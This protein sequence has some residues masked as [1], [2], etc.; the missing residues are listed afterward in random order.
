[1]CRDNVTGLVWEVKTSIPG[2]HHQNITYQ[3]GGLTAIGRKHPNRIGTYY[4]PSWNE[5]V[6][7]SN[8]ENLCGFNDWRLPTVSEL[9]SIVNKGSSNITIDA[10]Y[11][12][13][14]NSNWYWSSS[15]YANS[16]NSA[17]IVKL[18]GGYVNGNLR[19]GVHHV[20]LVRSGQ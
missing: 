17:W 18:Y 14:F 3:W 15:P 16:E 9:L 12:P 1:M 2:V 7:G 5:L 13:S 11:F 20:M 6:N 19:W 4:Y 10:N 8:N